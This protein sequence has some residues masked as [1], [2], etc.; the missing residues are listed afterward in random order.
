MVR[1]V[2]RANDASRSKRKDCQYHRGEMFKCSRAVDFGS[3]LRKGVC[4][5]TD[6]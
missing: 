2:Q 4:R 3:D 6:S 1:V 5:K